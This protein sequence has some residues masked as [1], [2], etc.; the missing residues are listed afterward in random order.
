MYNTGRSQN[1]QLKIFLDQSLQSTAKN[2]DLIMISCR[3]YSLQLQ[4]RSR[5]QNLQ[6]TTKNQVK[7]R[8]V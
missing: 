8:S 3:I 5:M 2:H 4:I 6:S 1:L 7:I